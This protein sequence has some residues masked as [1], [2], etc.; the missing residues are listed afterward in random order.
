M[1]KSYKTRFK[2]AIEE[3]ETGEIKLQ[4]ETSE[5]LTN[6]SIYI[7]LITAFKELKN[8]DPQILIN[9][10]F[11]SLVILEGNEEVMRGLQKALSELNCLPVGRSKL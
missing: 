7:A 6:Q 3:S 4:I 9:I 5:E 11:S 1:L 8:R 2:I 10:L